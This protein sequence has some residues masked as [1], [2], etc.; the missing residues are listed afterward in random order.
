MEVITTKTKH[1]KHSG[2]EKASP[3]IGESKGSGLTKPGIPQAML[4]YH[5][6]FKACE[7]SNTYNNYS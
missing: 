2:L 7:L 6:L 3:I 4:P 1:L 5:Q